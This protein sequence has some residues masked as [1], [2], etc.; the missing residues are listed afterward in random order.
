MTETK[1]KSCVLFGG[2][3]FI[4]SH[5]AADFLENNLVEHITLSDIV[6]ATP[7]KWPKN[8][9]LAFAAGKIDYVKVD[10]R[11]PISNDKL[12]SEVD[13]IVNLAAVHKEPGHEAHEYFATD[14]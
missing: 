9:Q 10:V 4:G 2:N 8:L 7:D 14:H 1:Y 3:G 6:T 11:N 5:L 12:P 13:L